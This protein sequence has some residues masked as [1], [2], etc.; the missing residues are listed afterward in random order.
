[1][2]AGYIVPLLSVLIAFFSL[3]YTIKN[4]NRVDADDIRSEAKERAA[5]NIKLDNIA[6]DTSEVKSDLKELRADMQV[7]SLKIAE[8]KAE[9][10][11]YKISRKPVLF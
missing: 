3:R 6:R 8:L 1:M 10:I 5:L 11:I 7:Q 4:N 2:D 9:Q